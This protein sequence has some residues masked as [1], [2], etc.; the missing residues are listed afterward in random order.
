MNKRDSIALEIPGKHFLGIEPDFL[1]PVG[2]RIQLHKHLYD[3][4]TTLILEVIE[5]EWRLQDDTTDINGNE[6]SPTFNIHLR[7]RIVK[8]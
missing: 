6:Q 4:G 1:P 5:H 3:G 2:T 7:T 8:P